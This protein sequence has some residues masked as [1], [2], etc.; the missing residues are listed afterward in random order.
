MNFFSELYL[1]GDMDTARKVIVKQ[2]QW[3]FSN[4]DKYFKTFPQHA[5]AY[6]EMEIMKNAT[7]FQLMVFNSCYCLDTAFN[8]IER[9]GKIMFVYEDHVIITTRD[10]KI[11]R[12][13]F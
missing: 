4:M 2:Q 10:G 11:K 9:E 12:V 6:L 7:D 3:A 13:D 1:K 5:K 8:V